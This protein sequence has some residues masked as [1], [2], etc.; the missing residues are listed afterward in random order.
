MINTARLLQDLQG[1]LTR[2]E[3]DL[4]A[5]VAE[6]EDVRE[7]LEAEWR[8]AFDAQRT[9][10]TFEEW[11]DD[12]L[13]QVAVGWLLACVFVRF[14]EDNGL[15]D[16]AR[17]GGSGVRG[18]EAREAQRR[19]FVENPNLSDREYLQDVFRAAASLPGLG[20]IVGEDESPLWLVD[21]P[22]DAA[23]RLLNVFRAE[24]ESGRL[25]HDFTDPDLDTRF[26]GDL[27]QDLSDHAKSTYALLQTPEFVE[28]FILDRTLT[29]AI[30]TFGLAKTTLIDPTC[31][32]G[33]F[34]LGAF[35]RLFEAWREAEP[36]AS[37]REH[38][39]RA[40]GA[41]TGVDLNPFAAAIARFRL[42][43]AAVKASHLS[44]LADAPDFT[45]DVAVGDSLLWGA[46]P[47]QLSGMEAAAT[48]ADRQFLY[49]T[50]HAEALRRIFDRQ[51]TAVV[52]N[53]PYIIARDKALN[54][55][56]RDRYPKACRGKYSLAAPFM[57]CFWELAATDDGYGRPAGFVGMITA[58]SFMKREF[59]KKLIE[60]LIPT[61]DLTHVIDTSGAYIPGHGTPTVILFG[62]RQRPVADTI[63]SVMGIRGEP[64]T[65]ADPAKGLVWSAIV[66]QVDEPGS[67]SQFISVADTERDRFASHPWSIG[68]GGA[69]ELK[70]RLDAA[71]GAISTLVDSIGITAVTGED[72][73]YVVGDERTRERSHVPLG[74][75]L[76]VGEA[77]R[78]WSLPPGLT[79][80]W[81]YTMDFDLLPPEELAGAGRQLWTCRAAISRRKRFGVPMIE[82]GLTWWEWQE[83]YVGKLR[84]PL[85]IAF[86]F[87]ATHNH[88]VLDRGGSVF[89]RSAP[90]IKLPAGSSERDHLALLGPLN[91]SV[92]CFWM[93][94][95]FHNKGASVDSKGARQTTVAWDNFYEHDG[96]KLQQFPLPAG[97][98]PVGSAERLDGLAAAHAERQP[99]AVAG[100]G[101][102]TR[103]ALDAARSEAERLF[104]EMVATQEE[105]DWECLHLYGLTEEALTVPEGSEAPPLK[106]GERAFEIVLARKLAAGEVETAWFTRHRSTPITELPAHW[107][108]WYRDLV[109]RRIALIESDRD[110][111]LVERPEH[112]RR[113]AREPWE[114]LEER[115]LRE[116]LADRLEDRRLWFEGSGDAERAVCRSVAQLADKVIALDPE[117]LEVARVWKGAVEVDAVAVVAELVADE[118]VPAQSAAR[119]KGK[120]F[121][122]RRVWERTWD[123]QRMED[124]G[125]P[126][127]DGLERIPVPPKYAQADFAKASYWKQ[128]GKLDVPK[129]RFTSIWGAERDAD[130]TLVLAWAGFDHAE[131]AQA[132]GSLVVERQQTDGWDPDRVWPLVVGLIELLP[133]LD[134]WHA[135][136]DQRWSQSPA[137]LYRQIAEQQALAGNRTLTDASDWRPPAAAGR[138]KK[139]AS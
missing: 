48:T 35:R 105:L 67:E 18:G 20:G 98:L 45:I 131:M 136:V 114:K 11:R 51:Y 126:L 90:V 28:E 52:G 66:A 129:E 34:L 24:D 2:W 1:E 106:L 65:P 4:T 3:A 122:K 72:D 135:E 77:L 112:K 113:W 133:W 107:P 58:N 21:P 27:Y 54:Q 102:P 73:L 19:F 31:G 62:R 115:A 42:L 23:T 60:E 32:S 110:I 36:G 59:G 39:E 25:V 88:F 127:P 124:R 86:A 108:D 46:R 71:G 63:R 41:V 97:P 111:G 5:R 80:I 89:N 29:P 104:A 83:L 38:A 15:I 103:A 10:R 22:A 84:T 95:V 125:E 91:S 120:G 9:G 117:F 130:P 44:R 116:W 14:G 55:Q 134:Q 17:L 75:L 132:I 74:P 78:N 118:H 26:L 40:L 79:V 109:D 57:Q 50:E 99:S 68:G 128:R 6:H 138:K 30:D 119:Y 85:S 101:A 53:P 43:V 94:Q 123:L 121:D 47:G 93:Q 92:A 7:R 100:R 96:T 16:E 37:E 64:S 70:Q 56:Y 76:V 61:W 33:H 13:T 137:Q 49:R 139:V 82:R 81:P 69:A 87:V 8:T 12:R